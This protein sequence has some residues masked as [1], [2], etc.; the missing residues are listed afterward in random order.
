MLV[1]GS[2][3]LVH[4]GTDYQVSHG[5]SSGYHLAHNL[6]DIVTGDDGAELALTVDRLI[7]ILYD[8]P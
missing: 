8:P 3:H 4:I 7:H 5:R 2:E 1:S 6:I